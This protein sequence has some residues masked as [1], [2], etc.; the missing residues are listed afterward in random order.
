MIPVK[1]YT[2]F[3]P[4]KHCIVGRATPKADVPEILKGVMERT[5]EDFAYIIKIL[6]NFGVRCYRP[7][8]EDLTKRPPLSPRDYFIVLGEK[9]F[10]GKVIPGYKNIIKQIDRDNIEWFLGNDI[11]SG[12]MIRCGSHIHWDVSKHVSLEAENKITDI[13]HRQDYKI[14]KTRYGWHMDGVYSILKPGVIVSTTE[15]PDLEDIYPNWEICYLDKAENEKPIKHDWGGD[16]LESNFDVNLLSIDESN[17]IV[18]A[19]NRKLFNFLES[20]SINPV[21]CR[22]RDR[23][24]WDNGIHCITQDLYRE[25]TKENYFT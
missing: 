22:F 19:V 24:F 9:L 14:Y 3:Q 10:V 7:E 1:G 11:S 17:C 21:V 4:L 23:T 12:N 18:P 25:G 8:I 16:Y 6:E 20:H 2:T 13:L 5:E 15:L